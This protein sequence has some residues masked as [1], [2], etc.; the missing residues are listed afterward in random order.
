VPPLAAP[1]LQLEVYIKAAAKVG[2]GLSRF[3][4][5]RKTPSKGSA[6]SQFTLEDLLLYSNVS[7]THCWPLATACLQ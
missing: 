6:P 7:Q 1:P 3:F 5:T 4:G 2:K